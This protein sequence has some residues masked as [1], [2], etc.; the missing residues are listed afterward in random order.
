MGQQLGFGNCTAATADRILESSAALSVQILLQAFNLNEWCQGKDLL[1]LASRRFF[2]RPKFYI[3]SRLYA[4]ALA[5]FRLHGKAKFPT[6]RIFRLRFLIRLFLFYLAPDVRR[7]G[8]A[9]WWLGKWPGS[10]SSPKR[11]AETRKTAE[12]RQQRCELPHS[13]SSISGLLSQ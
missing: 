2:G 7:V 4:L 5:P 6:F 10:S 3:G 1:L 8:C 11:R 12:T 13:R 9:S